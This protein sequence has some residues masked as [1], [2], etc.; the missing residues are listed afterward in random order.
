V[1]ELS[2]SGDQVQESPVLKDIAGDILDFTV[3]GDK[4]VVLEKEPL[5]ARAWGIFKGEN[6][7]KRNLYL[8]PLK[9]D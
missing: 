4:L 7:F 6:P 3:V 1:I 2:V 5:G 8:F 9:E